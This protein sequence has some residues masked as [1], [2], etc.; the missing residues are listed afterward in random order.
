MNGRIA[1]LQVCVALMLMPPSL[2]PA[3]EADSLQE[4][5]RSYVA[6]FNS[7]DREV[8][9]QAFPNA[10][11]LDFLATNV[12]LFE[13]PDAEIERTYYFRWW[14]F[15]KHLQH[16]PDGWVVTEFL[17][18]VPW[19]GK[20]NTISC[21]AGHHIR[22][23]RWLA[24]Q[25]FVQD[26]FA[27]WL[28]RGGNPRGYSFWIANSM[29]AWCD[30]TGDYA[31]AKKWLPNL[32][33]NYE[34]WEATR[35]DPVSGMYWQN[36]GADGME[37]SIGGSGFRSTINSY[38]Y[39]DA[40]AIARIAEMAGNRDLAKLYRE[41]AAKLK[42]LVQ[43]NLWNEATQFFH[44]R[45]M[46][47]TLGFYR[48]QLNEDAALTAAAKASSSAKG[49]VKNLQLGTVPKDSYK[50]AEPHFTFDNHLGTIEW[51]RYEL[52]LPTDV[53]STSLYLMA[54]GTF[55][56]PAAIKVLYRDAG[57]WQEVRELKGEISKNNRWNKL[58][59]AP[60][61]TDGVTLELTMQGNDRAKLDLA[62]V[63]EL[64]GYVPW[65]F[66][67]PD[68][69]FGAAWKQLIDLKGFSAP[70]GLTTAEQRH[71]E[72]KI[73]YDRHEC[74]W[75]GPVWPF[76]TAQ[77]LTA[78]ANYL[79]RESQPA[80]S[81]RDFLDALHTYA[82]SHRLTLAEDKVISWIDED[83]DPYNGDWIARRCILNWE[84]SA[85]AKWKSKGAT[86]DRGKDYNHSTFCDIVINGLV[87]L[88]PREDDIVELSPLVPDGA[89][90]WFCLDRVP[91]HGHRLTI[92]WDKSGHRYGK[93]A[94]L[95][96]FADDKEL[97]S[98]KSLI[99]IQGKLPPAS[100]N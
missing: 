11:A 82:R 78:L 44:V 13:C 42:H 43:A 23:G 73:H 62:G 54:G 19:A 38:Q 86:S 79:N 21:A 30:V 60:V 47:H 16:T 17:P 65:Y 95:H 9:S 64:H 81:R 1:L 84:K 56:P 59:F 55:A 96:L 12:P 68:S 97:T 24:D 33:R 66:D 10:K 4:K 77:T 32:L 93:G 100:T 70:W 63:R 98:A 87:G 74:L 34:A 94:G 88:R 40:L 48:W 14:T 37:G 6:R 67:L 57:Q 5:L 85:P 91:Y 39:G 29:L 71:P 25:K 3:A 8:F 35:Y 51:L 46:P 7:D 27:W 31:P 41:K 90:D 52:P 69:R 49:E 80:L 20:H 15:R 45:H 89:W 61:H 99:R 22:E 18:P 53:S 58:T 72:C 92:V 76:T 26:Y 75:N 2:A 36:D 50:W 83:Q 28:G